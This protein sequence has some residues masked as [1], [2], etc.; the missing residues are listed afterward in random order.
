MWILQIRKWFCLCI[1]PE[2]WDNSINR[3]MF[4][5][6]SCCAAIDFNQPAK[7]TAVKMTYCLILS[8]KWSRG[9][10]CTQTP[11]SLNFSFH[12]SNSQFSCLNR[13]KNCRCLKK[14]DSAQ[15]I[16][17]VRI[18]DELWSNKSLS[19]GSWELSFQQHSL[20]LLFLSSL[21]ERIAQA[22]QKRI[23]N[24]VDIYII[25]TRNY[26]KKLQWRVLLSRIF[27]SIPPPHSYTSLGCIELCHLFRGSPSLHKYLLYFC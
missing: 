5:H 11:H 7:E 14:G 17:M 3:L 24:E 23:T 4:A 25:A 21:T 1:T 9:Q 8:L 2:Y 10:V 27:H 13:G 19:E 20:V 26:N 16:F 6:C 18:L 15:M 22:K 12:C